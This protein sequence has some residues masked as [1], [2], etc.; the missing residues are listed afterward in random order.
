MSYGFI[1][2]WLMM[3]ALLVG[4]LGLVVVP[5]VRLV[6]P[7]AA[8]ALGWGTVGLALNAGVGLLTPFLWSLGQFTQLLSL[9]GMIGFWVGLA[10]CVYL[11]SGGKAGQS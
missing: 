8:R 2:P 7:K 6:D 9:A 3:A 5:R 10:I 1:T 11:L 4:V